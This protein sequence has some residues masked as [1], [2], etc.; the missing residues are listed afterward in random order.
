MK[1]QS[2]SSSQDFRSLSGRVIIFKLGLKKYHF[3]PILW[4]LFCA[5]KILYPRYLSPDI[6]D[7]FFC[8]TAENLCINLEFWFQVT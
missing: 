6:L 4:Y 8:V 7:E 5:C 3:P 1:D 2:S